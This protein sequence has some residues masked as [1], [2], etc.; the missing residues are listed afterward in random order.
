MTDSFPSVDDVT[1]K[2]IQTI[3]RQKFSKHTVLAVAH[4]LDTITDFD[5]IA[6]ID[7]GTLTEFDSPHVL[8]TQSSSA[9]QQLYS[10]SVA[11]QPKKNVMGDL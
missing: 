3:I 9:F 10:S 7:D 11:E 8:L 2:L 6:V 4:K 5:K 1:D